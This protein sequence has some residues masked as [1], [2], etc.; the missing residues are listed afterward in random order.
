MSTRNRLLSMDKG[1]MNSVIFLDIQ[2]VFDTVNHKILYNKLNCYHA[3]DEELLFF[4]SY[5]Q[6]QTQCSIINGYQETL[7]EVIS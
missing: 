7:K 3:S 4:A 6:S 1:N 2:K 5:L